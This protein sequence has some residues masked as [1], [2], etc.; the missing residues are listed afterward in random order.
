M[1]K[2]LF[3]F[4]MFCSFGVLAQNINLADALPM[5]PAV[6]VG[7]L[8][9]GLTYYI[10]PNKEPNKRAQLRL[11]IKA[12]SILETESQRG[13]AHFMEHMNFNGTKNFPKS[14]LLNFLEKS[15]I[16]FGADLNAYT[17]FDETV[18]ML[19]IPSDSLDKLD[20]YMMV[21][22]DWAGRALL[23]DSEIDKE[24]GVI[25]EEA[26]TRKGAGQRIQKK[27]L[28][29]I[30]N[31]SLYADR[32][33]IGLDTVIQ[34]APYAEF[35]KFKKDWYRPN[36]QAVV[37]V[38]DF[39]PALIEAMIMKHFSSLKNPK[40][41][42]ARIEHKVPLNGSNKAV[43]ITDSEQPNT[44]VQL[45][46]LSPE[47]Q[48]KTG[49]DKRKDIISSMFNTLINNRLQELLQKADPPFVFGRSSYGPY[50]GHLNALNV[51]A[52]AKGTDIEKALKSVLDENERASRFG[53]TETELERAKTNYMTSLEKA[54]KEKDKTNSE[55]YVEEYVQAFLNDEP[56]TS[57]DFDLAF[58]KQ[59]LGGIK[60][61]E[62]NALV[63]TLLVKQN[64]VMALIA[65]EKEKDKLPTEA[66]LLSWLDNTGNKIEAYV[67]E[68][69]AGS[70][71]ETAPVAGKIKSENTKADIGVTEITFENGVK[72]NLK[73][74]DFKNDEIIMSARSYG[75][76]SLYTDADYDNAAFASRAA[77]LSGNGKLT[78]VQ[79]KKFMTG[80]VASVNASIGGSTESISG[81]SNVKDFETMLQMVYNKFTNNNLDEAAVKGALTN[82]IASM[83]AMEKTPVPDKT[84]FDTVSAVMGGNI[85]RRMPGTAERMSKVNPQSAFNIF[86]DRFSNAADFEFTFVGNFDKEKIKPLLATYLGGLPT[87]P[88]KDKYNTYNDD[89][90][91]G[92]YEK[93]VKAGKEDK[94]TVL[95]IIHDKLKYT[96]LEDLHIS[97]LGEV[98]AIKLTEKLR[99]QEGGVYSPSVGGGASSWPKQEY[100]LSV[101]FPCKPSN[102][103]K[104]YGFAMDEI[105]KLVK[106]GP[107]DVDVEKVLKK[108]KLDLET[109]VK[110]NKYWLDNLSEAYLEAKNPSDI[111]N[112]ANLLSQVSK[113]SLKAAAA[114]YLT[115]PNITKFVLL[116][117][118]K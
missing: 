31:G 78:A 21:L 22:S 98:L 83:T 11:V 100:Q 32:L 90:P 77:G 60:V 47:T 10:H 103:D 112:D 59:V 70:L 44:V 110:T 56:S 50:I 17:S 2:L 114:K 8:K 43:I 40:K 115:K 118:D 19:P 86:K 68:K 92:N 5:N 88:E 18:Y 38:G 79:L 53:F 26:R 105:Q 52:V 109:N 97:C 39:D 80:K 24:R 3:G 23:E 89:A 106:N 25:L 48:L 42:K 58:A 46:Y 73:S 63:K 72:V 64:R 116:P 62:V 67:D 99:E 71:V 30:F 12:G 34:Y 55:N 95:A 87:R 91:K 51:I 111:L 104:L 29:V 69:V 74:T 35:K 33:P 117:E 85:Y 13:L 94:A 28:P 41:P 9:N 7:K 101:Y 57:Q 16:Q 102:V 1:K 36:L 81:N 20:K 6:K 76:T 61:E 4:L 75:G 65:P 49:T 14:E 84:F 27:L 66:Q 82:T 45:Y 15:G 54:V 37:A 93:I 113:E 108:K 107:E 96:D